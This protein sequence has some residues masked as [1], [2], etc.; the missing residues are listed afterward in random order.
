M[1]ENKVNRCSVCNSSNHTFFIVT[2]ALMHKQNNE[3][4]YFNKCINCDTVFLTNPVIES[5]LSDYYTTNYLPYKGALAWGKYSSFVEKNQKKLDIL[6]FNIV[7]KELKKLKK[8]INILDVGCGNPSFLKVV[9]E[10][11][12]VSCTGIDF[13][14]FGWHDQSYDD[15]K[16]KKVAIEDFK[17]NQLFDII[18]LWHYLE[19]DYHPQKTIDKLYTL[20]K[21]GGK[22]IIEV[23]DYHSI[24]A[25]RQ[26][27]YWQGWHSPRHLSLFSKNS[28]FTLFKDKKWTILSHKRYGTLDAFTLWWLGKMEHEN[29]DWSQNMEKQFM[30]LVFLKIITFPFF[31]FERIFPMGI[32]TIIVKK[33]RI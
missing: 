1:I 29:M 18:T 5:S 27:E 15:L 24:T 19:H 8:D 2:K 13:S 28:F 12:N 6:R 4:Y 16:L 11:L 26:K 33:D 31:V 32:Q 22:V 23:P 3:K 9:K 25:K 14:D 30:Q 17:T 21:P 7:K 20:L 10:N